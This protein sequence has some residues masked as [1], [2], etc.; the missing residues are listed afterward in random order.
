MLTLEDW[1][2]MLQKKKRSAPGIDRISYD[3]LRSLK[4]ETKITIIR[5]LNNIYRRGELPDQLKNIKL[6][7][8]LKPGRDPSDINSYRPI[9][10]LPTLTKSINHGVLEMVKRH[11]SHHNLLPE[12]SF[13]FQAKKSTESC[14]EYATNILMEAKRN[15]KI[16]I[17]VFFDFSNAFDTVQ[18]DTLV[19]T[20]QDMNFPNDIVLWIHNFLADRRVIIQTEKGQ[21]TTKVNNGLPQGDVL[22][23]TLF[24]IYT[25]ALHEDTEGEFTLQYA[26]DFFKIV[27]GTS[28]QLVIDKAQ[29]AVN[30]F[31]DISTRLNLK[32]NKNK[33]KVILFNDKNVDVGIK[34]ENT[35]VET[36]RHY[37]YLGLHLDRDLK[38]GVHARVLKQKIT[39]RQNML[40]IISSIKK[41]ATPKVMVLFHKA[42]YASYFSYAS[43]VYGKLS[44]TYQGMLEVANRQCQRIATGCSKTTPINTLAVLSNEI[45]LHIKRKYHTQKRIAK[46]LKQGD[47]I[48]EQLF[49]LDTENVK[50]EKLYTLIEWTYLEN[51]DS[52]HKIYTDV[53]SNISQEIDVRTQVEG[54]PVQK[55]K[56]TPSTM[57]QIAMEMINTKYTGWRHI[58]TDA[59]RT[60]TACGVGIFAPQECLNIQM[61]LGEHCC[62]MTAEMIAIWLAVKEIETL[63][64]HPTVILTDSQSACWFLTSCKEKENLDQLSFE[65][66]EG[67][68]QTGT[69]LQWIPAHVGI[70]G[71]EK[72]DTLAKEGL[73]CDAVL[74]NK[75]MWQDIQLQIKKRQLEEANSWYQRIVNDENKGLKYYQFTDHFP[76]KPWYWNSNLDG[77]ETRMLNRI[78]AGHD[79]SNF[80]LAKMRIRDTENCELCDE[81]DTT[82]HA[83]LYC[84][85]YYHIRNYFDWEQHHNLKQLIGNYDENKIEEV[86]RFIRMAKLQP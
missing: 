15:N 58:Y 56:M 73:D 33:T 50:E 76:E 7:P 5:E 37:K 31:L 48:S 42:L 1:N 32:I 12:L 10:L 59:S 46:H 77:F 51:K 61:K 64:R 74:M 54:I 3:I 23:P 65:I 22:S 55:R 21:V 13:G 34:I 24:N 49:K 70:R 6:L 30:K 28:R 81:K 78:L 14:L 26:D 72:A 63:P 20:L 47:A 25:A 68:I 41:G 9:A 4:T 57:Y 19:K 45:P 66:C 16:S 38:F 53:K 69:V 35:A 17:G 85:K 75:L 39:E 27:S 80:W 84:V 8:I 62:I 43:S 67:L 2:S 83:L 29:N 86:I 40:K 18:V 82:E 79:F 44:K 36:V 71:N 52:L 60:E 11:I